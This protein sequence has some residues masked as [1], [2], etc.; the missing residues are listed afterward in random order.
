MKR[1]IAILV[2]AAMLIGVLCGCGKDGAKAGSNADYRVGFAREDVMPKTPVS[3]GGYGNLKNR[4]NK[5]FLDMLYAHATAITD[6]EDN[7]LLIIAIDSMNFPDDMANKCR[8]LISEKLGIPQVN[9]LI[10][11]SHSH[12]TPQLSVSSGAVGVTEH[13]TLVEEK[14]IAAAEAAMASRVPAKMQFTKFNIDGL[15]FVKHIKM[16]DGSYAGDNFGDHTKGYAEYATTADN[17]MRVIKFDREEGDDIILYNWQ[18]HP[19]ITGG[20]NK[21]DLSADYVGATR[22]AFEAQNPGNKL[23]FFQGCAGD[24]NTRSYFQEDQP[25]TD[26]KLFGQNLSA[27]IMMGLKGL[28]DVPAGTVKATEFNYVG[29]VNHSEDHLAALAQPIA[30]YFW[31]TGD[32][33]GGNEMCKPVGLNSVY[34][35]EGILSKVKMGETDSLMI[36]AYQIGPIGLIATPTEMFN[37]LGEYIRENSPY[38]YTMTL[39]YS[40]GYYTYLPTEFAYTYNP[41]E[42][43]RCPLEAGNGEK[44]AEK[45]V[46][47]LE[48]LKG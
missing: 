28:K 2:L 3:L 24:M 4:V 35:C 25:T 22:D 32:R 34:H 38:D 39:G 14:V 42:V 20:I 7:T 19:L 48:E 30:S 36:Y 31:S 16:N 41:Y 46:S 12:S 9:V 27:Q 6:K 21:T 8:Q 44:I 29:K 45:L 47:M 15:N 23:V 18:G 10:N 17:E 1:I 26:N 43:N 37:D 33:V 11:A 5:G 13:R 40:N